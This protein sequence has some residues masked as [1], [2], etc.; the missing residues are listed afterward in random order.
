[1][2][3]VE[4]PVLLKTALESEYHV[5]SVPLLFNSSSPRIFAMPRK[6]SVVTRSHLSTDARACL[7][8]S[9]FLRDLACRMGIL[10]RF[11]DKVMGSIPSEDLAEDLVQVI[12]RTMDSEKRERKKK[13]LAKDFDTND[14]ALLER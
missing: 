2:R 4:Q 11:V 12:H 8:F 3:A 7:S 14:E 9:F 10:D 1:M 6:N 5:Q 13:E